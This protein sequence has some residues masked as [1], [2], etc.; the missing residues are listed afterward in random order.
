MPQTLAFK[1]NLYGTMVALFHEISYA[2]F[3][4]PHCLN[5]ILI[6]LLLLWVVLDNKNS[7]TYCSFYKSLNTYCTY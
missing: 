5:I 2:H 6:A 7:T 1:K 4:S 3:A